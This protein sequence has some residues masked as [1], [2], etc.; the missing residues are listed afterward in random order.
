MTVVLSTSNQQ[1]V[2]GGY[3]GVASERSAAAA[4][5]AV[6]PHHHHHSHSHKAGL[7]HR[8]TAAAVRAAVRVAPGARGTWAGRIE[9]SGRRGG[10]TLHL[11]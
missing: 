10:T 8:T 9:I 5:K 11:H 4:A 3:R 6:T 7:M 1:V 2:I